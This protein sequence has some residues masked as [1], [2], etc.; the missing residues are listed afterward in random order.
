[1]HRSRGEGW[2]KEA[3]RELGEY[4]GDWTEEGTDRPLGG[5]IVNCSQAKKPYKRKFGVFELQEL[6]KE[7]KDSPVF[8]TDRHGERV[9][10]PWL[11]E[12]RFQQALWVAGYI[13]GEEIDE[14]KFRECW[15]RTQSPEVETQSRQPI[16]PNTAT[17][18]G[19]RLKGRTALD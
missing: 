9:L 11:R 10:E 7:H 15:M 5:V 2:A 3:W 14:Q 4:L 16:L 8:I 12:L 18:G 19:Y 17:F 13:L 1:M 6:A